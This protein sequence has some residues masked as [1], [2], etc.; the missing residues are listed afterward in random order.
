[1]KRKQISKIYA[2]KICIAQKNRAHIPENSVC[3]FTKEVMI[4]VTVTFTL[5]R[6]YQIRL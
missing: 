6:Q 1:M 2:K 3:T 5:L 4:K